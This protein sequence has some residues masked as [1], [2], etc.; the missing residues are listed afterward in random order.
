MQIR[1][2]DLTGKKIA[3]FLQEHLENMHEITPPESVHALDLVA[4]RSSDITF[5]SAWE[6]DELLG[7]GALKELDSRSGEVKS[8]RTAKAHRNKGV[9]SKILE[10][11]IQEAKRR[12]YD[13]LNLETGAMLEFAPAR[14]L[15][16]KYGFEY[17]GPFAEY[18]DDP[19]SV[20][21]TKKL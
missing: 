14:A 2:D 7:C 1:E 10:H 4:L 6:G 19:N 21:M 3:E 20:F 15:Y 5:W 13:C 17:R 8:M 16:I 18:I 11:I 9:A 12:A